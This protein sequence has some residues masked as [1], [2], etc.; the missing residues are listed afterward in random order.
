MA[1]N[2]FG[3]T[4]VKTPP[5]SVFTLTHEKQMTMGIGK[6][7]PIF[8]K[9]ILPDDRFQIQSEFILRFNPMIAPVLGRMNADIHYFFI[10]G[11]DLWAKFYDFLKGLD[12]LGREFTALNPFCVSVADYMAMLR[13]YVA[14]YEESE[15][16]SWPRIQDDSGNEFYSFAG[17]ILDYLGY[18]CYV[19]MALNPSNPSSMYPTDEYIN[20]MKLFT[21]HKVY[22]EYYSKENLEG[23]AFG[24][25]LEKISYYAEDDPASTINDFAGALNTLFG[26]EIQ[27]DYRGQQPF[28]NWLFSLHLRK[29][30]NDYFTSANPWTQKGAAPK[31]PLSVN[32]AEGSSSSIEIVG[33]DVPDNVATDAQWVRDESD[34]MI[35]GS[36][37]GVTR[38]RFK[39]DP[40]SPS[41][42]E[43]YFNISDL[44]VANAIQR[45]LEKFAVAGTRVNEYLRSVFGTQDPSLEI[46]RAQ[47]LGGTSTP[48]EIST[49]YQSSETNETALGSMAGR[50]LTG[51]VSSYIDV[52]E[53]QHGFIIGIM[54]IRPRIYYSNVVEKENMYF[55]R[56]D[57]PTPDLQHVGEQAIKKFEL[58]GFGPDSSKSTDIT[59]FG[60]QQRYGEAKY[61]PN[62]RHG[63]L[64]RYESLGYWSAFNPQDGD[65]G[66]LFN[67]DRL[68]SVNP[69]DY[70]MM[71][72]YQGLGEND[73]NNQLILNVL[74]K[75]SA[76]RPLSFYS[77][78]SL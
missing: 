25:I 60:Y 44:R 74:N 28:F 12:K 52:K 4:V 76:R 65:Q 11:T 20:L 2:P 48:I 64:K 42:L 10:K 38:V 30:P 55:D 78:P 23:D 41:V 9:F 57:Y 45:L 69:E 61:I 67:L 46:G 54:S 75:V 56:F 32:F 50:S 47:Y 15:R 72:N 8:H 31:V 3:A 7:I 19:N 39:D 71:F 14:D 62:T 16:V 18:P 27:T 73:L 6:L 5:K 70:S 22:Y 1:K 34:N 35:L 53:R 66:K 13:I 36:Y 33:T 21:Y 77:T 29:Y 51:G 40:Q 43:G 26:R 63:L 17:T 37:D 59:T 24:F 49:V 58:T 68:V